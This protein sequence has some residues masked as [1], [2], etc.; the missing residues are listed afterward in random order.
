MLMSLQN[1][2]VTKMVWMLA[3]N[4]LVKQ[5]DGRQPIIAIKTGIGEIELSS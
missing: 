4:M 3:F 1:M 5:E 2:V